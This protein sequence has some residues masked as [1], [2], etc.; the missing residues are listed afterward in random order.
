MLSVE[1]I[2]DN[3]IT[4]KNADQHII[5]DIFNSIDPTDFFLICFLKGSN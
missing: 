4:E 3:V 5:M 1:N 2:Y